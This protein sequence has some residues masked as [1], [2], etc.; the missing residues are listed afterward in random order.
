[1]DCLV[2]PAGRH[3][4]APARVR[5]ETSVWSSTAHESY[6]SPAA[7][8]YHPTQTIL[9]PALLAAGQVSVPVRNPA[10]LCA[11]VCEETESIRWLQN[12]EE[13]TS[14][15]SEP[16]AACTFGDRE[17]EYMSCSV[18]RT[19]HAVLT[20]CVP[21]SLASDGDHTIAT[22]MAE[23]RCKGLHRVSLRAVS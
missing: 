4:P 18:K 2:G 19:R 23:L 6:M 9:I 22:D 21:G 20:A 5:I 3:S 1:M 17:S 7:I 8:P 14:L 11:S 16:D 12:L 15:L 13:S 10:C